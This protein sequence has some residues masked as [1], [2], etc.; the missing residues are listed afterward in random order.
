MGMACLSLTKSL[1]PLVVH[2]LKAH[3]EGWHFL[4]QKIPYKYSVK[5]LHSKASIHMNKC[6]FEQ[7]YGR[8]SIYQAS[9]QF[10]KY[11]IKHSGKTSIQLKMYWIEQLSGDTSIWSNNYP[12]EQ[13]FSQTSIRLNNHPV[14][15]LFSQ[16]SVWL[17]KY[18]M[19][20]NQAGQ[21]ISRK[22]SAGWQHLSQLKALSAFF[23]LQKKRLKKKN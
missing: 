23:Y 11:V 2:A 13:L 3:F 22:Q 10:D 14:E 21:R 4:S 1:V 19:E 9:I 6:Q 15:Q 7:I 12:V 20:E 17:N 18:P 16:I 8:T 5:Q